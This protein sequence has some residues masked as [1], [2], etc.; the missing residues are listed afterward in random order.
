MQLFATDVAGFR[1]LTLDYPLY[2]MTAAWWVGLTFGVRTS[3]TA[4]VGTP[5]GDLQL[6]SAKSII[7]VLPDSVAWVCDVAGFQ[8]LLRSE[9]AV[10]SSQ[11]TVK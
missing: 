7:S 6:R 1:K 11:N 5:S 10:I 8:G 2:L 3:T 9:I 4:N